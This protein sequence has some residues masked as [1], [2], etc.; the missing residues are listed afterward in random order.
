M[1]AKEAIDFLSRWGWEKA[2]LWV[3]QCASLSAAAK[4][5]A[6]GFKKL[7][8]ALAAY[9]IQEYWALV[10]YAYF[11]FGASRAEAE[12]AMPK[13]VYE[14]YASQAKSLFGDG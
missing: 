14:A 4:L 6:W 7:Q 9:Q 2:A 10:D 5:E 11:K 13:A 8:E 3:R 12:A 1:P